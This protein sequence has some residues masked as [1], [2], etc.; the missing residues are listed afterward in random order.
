MNPVYWTW[1]RGFLYVKIELRKKNRI[2]I[3]IRKE[4]DVN[5]GIYQT[6]Y[7]MTKR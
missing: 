2:F 7:G 3:I 5:K 1:K 4:G 6:K